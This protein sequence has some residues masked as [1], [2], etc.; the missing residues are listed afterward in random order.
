MPTPKRRKFLIRQRWKRSEKRRKLPD[1]IDKEHFR[2][3]LSF[4]RLSMKLENVLKSNAPPTTEDVYWIEAQIKELVP[5]MNKFFVRT[6][7]S[8]SVI[9]EKYAKFRRH[10]IKSTFRKVFYAFEDVDKKHGTKFRE[11]FNK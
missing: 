11:V 6:F 8:E 9:G 7:K 4:E 5:R 10:D 2:L 3:E 1:K